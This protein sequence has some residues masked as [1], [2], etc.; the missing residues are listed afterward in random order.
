MLSAAVG[1]RGGPYLPHYRVE[2]VVAPRRVSYPRRSL[3]APHARKPWKP[4]QVLAWILE[5]F[6]KE[7][8]GFVEGSFVLRTEARDRVHRQWLAPPSEDRLLCRSDERCETS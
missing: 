7:E 6:I 8:S 2:A 3:V 1:V 5:I 4:L